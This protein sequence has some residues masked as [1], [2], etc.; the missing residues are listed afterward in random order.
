MRQAVDGRT[1]MGVQ[2]SPLI[3]SRSV[4]ESV[5]CI[6]LLRVYLG[7][8]AYLCCAL[9]H[10]VLFSSLRTPLPIDGFSSLG[11][12]NQQKNETPPL[13]AV[14]FVRCCCAIYLLL[15]LFIPPLLTFSHPCC[16]SC[17][18][19]HHLPTDQ[20]TPHLTHLLRAPHYI[21]IYTYLVRV[22]LVFLSILVLGILRRAGEERGIKPIDISNLYYHCVVSQE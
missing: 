2:P 15:S 22:A 19:P 9:S 7:H 17:T 18:P 12:H 1:K 5:V 4:P 10:P 20:R 6:S 8:L 13:R 16:S 14:L 3:P 21:V 11:T